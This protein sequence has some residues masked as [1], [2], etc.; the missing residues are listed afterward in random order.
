MYCMFGFID[1]Y[2]AGS[3]CSILS[4]YSTSQVSL[5][6]KFT[7]FLLLRDLL[8]LLVSSYHFVW[9]SWLSLVMLNHSC[10]YFKLFSFVPLKFIRNVC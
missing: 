1:T 2:D 7:S 4:K 9:F 5:Y 6:D 3:Y 8:C 10:G